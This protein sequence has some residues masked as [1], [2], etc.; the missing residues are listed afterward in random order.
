VDTQTRHALKQD[1]FVEATATT[2]DWLKDNRSSVLKIIIPVV[3]VAAALIAGFVLWNQR[4]DQAEAALGTALNTYGAPLAQPGQQALPGTYATSADRARVANKQFLEVAEKYG[5]LEAGKQAH[6]FA[7]LSYMDL[8]QTGPAEAEL[9]K[10]IS[11]GNS[12]LESLAKMA[13]AGLYH[14]TGRDSQAIDLYKQLIAK[15]S[16]AVPAGAA[17]LALAEIYES[18]N[19]ISAAKEIYAKVKDSDK[20]T[21]AGRIADQKLSQLK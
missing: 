15:P 7:G 20:D 8:G 11:S 10:A 19:N 12:G 9:Q 6:Y 14:K 21:A 1:H 5:W 16:D 4:S 2:L 3:V 17:Q 18:Q 13:L